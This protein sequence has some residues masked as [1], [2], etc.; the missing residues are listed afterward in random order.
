MM[1]NENSRIRLTAMQLLERMFEVEMKFIRSG[2]DDVAA[3]AEAFHPDVVVHEPLSLPYPGDWK[4]LEGAGALFRRMREVWSD[5]RVEGLTAAREADTV[6]MTCTLCLTCR[7]SGMTIRQPFAEV[8]RFQD[9]RLI[10]A[11]PFYYD[12]SEIVSA[13][14]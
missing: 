9:E 12:T 7:T 11:T 14:G 5:M 10:E 13:L 2:A 4:G 8:L 3:L 6:F 1:M